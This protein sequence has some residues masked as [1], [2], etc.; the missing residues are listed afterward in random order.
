MVEVRLVR[1]PGVGML[2]SFTTMA[3]VEVSVIAHR[4]GVSDLVIRMHGEDRGV[5][6][7]RLDE[8]EA[9]TLADLLGGTRIVQSIDDLDDLPGVPIDWATVG[10]HDSLAGH[11]LGSLA[12]PDGVVI[13]ALVRGESATPTP[14]PDVVVLPGDI[15]VAVGPEE[16]VERAFRAISIGGAA[17]PPA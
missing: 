12:L 3:G 13:V 6:N 10:E 14:A 8:E 11:P 7:L 2:H 4:T 15:L 9:R 1:L 16:G 5:S 17:E